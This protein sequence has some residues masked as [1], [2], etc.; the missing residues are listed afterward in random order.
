MCPWLR[1]SSNSWTL[2]PLNN[3]GGSYYAYFKAGDVKVLPSQ[4]TS[5]SGS[6]DIPTFTCLSCRTGWYLS[7]AGVCSRCPQGILQSTP[8]GATAVSQC[9]CAPGAY[10][11][12]DGNCTACPAG[13]YKEA[14]GNANS[15]ACAPCGS[16]TTSSAGAAVCACKP[17]YSVATAT[18]CTPALV[19]SAGQRLAA[20]HASCEGC[21]VDTYAPANDTS[22]TSCKPCAAGSWTNGVTGASS[23]AK[24]V[25]RP[26]FMRIGGSS[27]CTR[28]FSDLR[29]CVV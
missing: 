14:L 12:S 10:L 28:T 8:V 11:G 4:V 2:A 13:T 16:G 18:T 29:R 22:P 24:C 25:C 21:P 1:R 26:G 6:Y 9:S 5:A 3:F 7:G 27:T 17:G 19:C 20:D 23:V 15:T